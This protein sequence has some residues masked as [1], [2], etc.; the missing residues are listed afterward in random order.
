MT[1]VEAEYPMGPGL[2][3]AFPPQPCPGKSSETWTEKEVREM[4]KHHRVS[5]PQPQGPVS[6]EQKRSLTEDSGDFAA[7]TNQSYS[8]ICPLGHSVSVVQ[9]G[10]KVSK[11]NV[12]LGDPRGESSSRMRLRQPLTGGARL[13]VAS[14]LQEPAGSFPLLAWEGP[15]ERP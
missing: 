4:E 3:D 6:R 5:E 7:L 11:G 12:A 15:Q 10:H 1:Q 2:R 8:L 9:K 14:Y 13:M